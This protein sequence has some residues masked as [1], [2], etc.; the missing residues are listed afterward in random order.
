[1]QI[2]LNLPL[3]LVDIGLLE[4]QVGETRTNTKH[5]LVGVIAVVI[6]GSAYPLMEVRE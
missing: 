2:T 1:M 4:D 6:L 3:V 5:K